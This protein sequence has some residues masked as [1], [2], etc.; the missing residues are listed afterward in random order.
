[1]AITTNTSSAPHVAPI[2][3]QARAIEFKQLRFFV[4]VVDIGSITR[5]SQALHIAQP[6]LSKHLADLEHALNATLLIR[7]SQGIQPTEQGQALYVAAKRILRDVDA[8]ASEVSAM[9]REPVGTVRLG[10]LESTSMCLAY[11][12]AVAIMKRYP[13]V[14]LVLVAGQGRDLYRRLL[15][16]DLDL[17]VLSPDEEITGVQSR[18]LL[19]EELFVVGSPA[20]PG[21]SDG[22]SVE[23]HALVDVPFVL[24]SKSSF[25]IRRLM[26]DAFTAPQFEPNVVIEAD[27]LVLVKRLVMEGH[28]CSV[29]PWAVVQDEVE[30]DRIRLKRIVGIP[31][32]RRLEL[33]RRPDQ[34]ATAA[35]DA[36]ASVTI[37]T[38]ARLVAS[39]DWLHVAPVEGADWQ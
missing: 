20:M 27:A 33:C 11:P 36:V 2:G 1:M 14:R 18:P 32:Q 38:V 31:L 23:L 6:A 5:A 15:A 30:A 8:I 26:K 16:G 9:G 35:A 29:L 7:G 34:P 22:S 25:S 10:C 39:G 12:L 4:R 24:P 28:G 13:L 37:E 3:D 19:D 21:F 17:V